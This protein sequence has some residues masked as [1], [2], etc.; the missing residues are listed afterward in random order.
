MPT[1]PAR[2][3][4]WGPRSGKLVIR[5]VD[6]D[7]TTSDPQEPNQF[8]IA[9]DA[10]GRII[11][12]TDDGDIRLR[13]FNLTLQRCH[14]KLEIS[15][16]RDR[17]YGASQH[18]SDLTVQ[19]KRWLRNKDALSCLNCDQQQRLDQFIRAIAR[20]NTLR[21]PAGKLPQSFAQTSR[22]EVRITRPLAS[23]EPSESLLLDSH[24]RICRV[25]VLVDLH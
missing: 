8:L 21:C 17:L 10:T 4:G 5:L 9:Y 14:V 19:R 1:T 20:D 16:E 6:N 2:L 13:L 12:R 25:L 3:L 24:R 11:W 18:G 23:A 15:C 7:Q 22:H